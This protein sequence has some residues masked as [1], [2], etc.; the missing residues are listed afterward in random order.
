M[1]LRPERL[2]DDQHGQDDQR[3]AEEAGPQAVLDRVAAERG[4]DRALLEVGDAGRQRAGAQHRR[5]VLR[6]L[7]GEVALDDA[8]GR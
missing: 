7:L 8:R 3:G 4:A 2:V 6:L 5:Q 1:A